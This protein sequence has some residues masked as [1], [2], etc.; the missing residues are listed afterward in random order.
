MSLNNKQLKEEIDYIM[1]Y[2]YK[3][4]FSV[5]IKTQ[6]EYNYLVDLIAKYGFVQVQQCIRIASSIRGINNPLMEVYNGLYK[7]NHVNKEELM[8]IP[9]F[10]D[11]EMDR[12]NRMENERM[13][14]LCN[15]PDKLYGTGYP[16][17]NIMSTRD[18]T[19]NNSNGYM[20]WSEIERALL[21]H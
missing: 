2:C 15:D 17:F 9:A 20:S 8:K 21:G 3:T 7:M 18:R 13:N 11:S 5:N 4:G 10:A 6:R 16:S 12:L 19:E 1:S 14:S